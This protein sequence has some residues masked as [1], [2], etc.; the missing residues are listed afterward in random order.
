MSTFFQ[1]SF[2]I[3]VLI[4]INYTLKENAFL[5]EVNGLGGIITL[6]MSKKAWL[7]FMLSLVWK[8]G[9][10]LW[11]NHLILHQKIK[12]QKL[13]QIRLQVSTSY[14]SFLLVVSS[15]SISSLVYFSLNSIRL[16]VK[17]RKDSQ[18]QTWIGKISKDLFWQQNLSMRAQMCQNIQLERSSTILF[19][20]KNLT[21]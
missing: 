2:S 14:F 9:Q 21:L 4:C 15:S 6:M 13:R 17:K 11:Y 18:M 8:D 12:D 5:L 20:Q 3:V 16:R 19:P 7:L 10:I 1:E